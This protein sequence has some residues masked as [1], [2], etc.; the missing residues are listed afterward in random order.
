MGACYC[1]K[2]YTSAFEGLMDI[3]GDTDPAACEAAAVVFS[4]FIKERG[5]SFESRADASYHALKAALKERDRFLGL[6]A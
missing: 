5:K 2:Q 3:T 4:Q 6:A 1:C